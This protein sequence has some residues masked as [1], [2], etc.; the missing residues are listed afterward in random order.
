MKSVTFQGNPVD[1]SGNFPSKGQTIKN[2]LLCNS[3]LSDITL[4]NF[5]ERNLIMY[6]YPSVDTPVC[7]KSLVYLNAK[8]K[9]LT[10]TTVLCISADLPFATNRFCKNE[11]LT[12]IQTA[13]FFRSE[14]FTEDYGVNLNK[15]VLRGLAARSIIIVNSMGIIV[16]SELVDEITNEPDYDTINE[17]LET[18]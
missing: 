11:E 16:H 10:N 1:I 15:G 4:D 12:S 14:N 8:A 5:E 17:V 7:S 6:T 13:S 2:F 18:L 3:D 9:T